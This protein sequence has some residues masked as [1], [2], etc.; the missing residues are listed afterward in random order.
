MLR[1]RAFLT[2]SRAASWAWPGTASRAWSGTGVALETAP[3][4]GV[5]DAHRFDERALVDHLAEHLPR[6]FPEGA[7]ELDLGQFLH[8]QS[9]PTFV[10][11][12]PVDA[13]RAFVLRKQPPGELLKGAHA[14]DREFTI[15]SALGSLSSADSTSGPPVPK[16]RHYCSDPSVLGTPFFVYDFVPGRFYADP[17][18]RD[19]SDLSAGDRRA[20]YEAL[21]DAMA[22]VHAVKDPASLNGMSSF[23]RSEDYVARQLKIW[24]RQ[25]RA[26]QMDD[27]SAVA[28]AVN[29]DMNRLI[30]ALPE[31]APANDANQGDAFIVHGDL[32]MDNVIFRPGKDPAVAAI[33]IG[34]CRRSETRRCS[35]WLTRR[36]ATTSRRS[37]I[38]PSKDFP[39]SIRLSAQTWAFRLSA[40]TLIC[41]PPPWRLAAALCAV[42]LM[43]PTSF[44]SPPRCSKSRR[45]FRVCTRAA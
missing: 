29:E 22:G 26:A 19:E 44:S 41:T 15:M 12:S 10:V 11:Q 35:T 5:R 28:S 4:T 34:S 18:L 32:R 7:A 2:A 40:S 31:L 36:C 33:L 25:F 23:G 30:D 16:M 20:M 38:A 9:N 8:G 27:G 24:T 43:P 39:T 13:S 45:S 37:R 42:T 6:D 1:R 3:V 17:S 21:A 14:V